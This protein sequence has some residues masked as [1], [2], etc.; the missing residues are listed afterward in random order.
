M[1]FFS[2]VFMSNIYNEIK[3]FALLCFVMRVN[4][5]ATD[6][7]TFCFV[8]VCVYVCVPQYNNPRV[9]AHSSL[10]YPAVQSRDLADPCVSA[11]SSLLAL[12]VMYCPGIMPALTLCKRSTHT[13][14]HTHTDKVP[15]VWPLGKF[16]T[17]NKI[18]ISVSSLR[19]LALL[20]VTCS[21]CY[22]SLL[23]L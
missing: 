20:T 23:F 7:L 18:N 8:C 1:I 11:R 9:G 3:Y 4:S 13:L 16:A 10:T 14:S 12:I 19:K 15:Q 5:L 17:Y 6:T 21:A 22:F 2:F